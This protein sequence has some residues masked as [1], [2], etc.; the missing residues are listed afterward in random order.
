MKVRKPSRRRDIAAWGFGIVRLGWEVGW[1]IFGVVFDQRSGQRD[2]RWRRESGIKGRWDL[3][4]PVARW[5]RKLV[6]EW[7]IELRDEDS[8]MRLRGAGMSGTDFGM[9]RHDGRGEED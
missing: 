2:I 7:R 4:E 8:S 3:A 1:S 9:P 6:I 5:A